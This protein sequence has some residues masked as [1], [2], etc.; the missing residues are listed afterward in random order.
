[1]TRFDGK[2]LFHKEDDIVS[3][4]ASWLSQQGSLVINARRAESSEAD[5]R[6]VDVI[7]RFL[8]VKHVRTVDLNLELPI[9]GQERSRPLPRESR[10]LVG[11]RIKFVEFPGLAAKRGWRIGRETWLNLAHPDIAL[12]YD[13]L[14]QHS[15]SPAALSAA[16]LVK[17]AA[18]DFEGVRGGLINDLKTSVA[19]INS[20]A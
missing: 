8:S 19:E 20:D 6:E 9:Q 7:S 10:S 13:V 2:Q 17:L 5:L 1:L 12:C 15:E 16:L 14:S 11:A 18:L 3:L 4:Q